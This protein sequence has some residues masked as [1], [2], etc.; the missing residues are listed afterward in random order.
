[1]NRMPYLAAFVLQL[2]VTMAHAQ[3]I[4]PTRDFSTNFCNFPHAWT[5][6]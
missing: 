1:M 3:S 5:P 4:L 6:M 2:C